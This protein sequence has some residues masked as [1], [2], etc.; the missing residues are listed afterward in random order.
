MHVSIYIFNSIYLKLTEILKVCLWLHLYKNREAQID[1]YV[2]M[3]VFECVHVHREID[4]RID[5]NK[6]RTCHAYKLLR[7]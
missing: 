4:E 2:F 3:H 1:A 7:T 5:K 6:T